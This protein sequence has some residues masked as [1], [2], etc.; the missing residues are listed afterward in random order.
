MRAITR[1]PILNLAAQLQESAGAGDW[2]R[3][4]RLDRQV[5]A[6]LAAVG[7]PP[8]E[9]RPALKLLKAAH[10]EAMNRVRD[11]LRRLQEHIRELNH[12]QEGL[13][14]YAQSGEPL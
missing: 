12:N 11:E 9:L 10:G 4:A 3:V 6:L 7:T 2:A 5:A 13:K 1:E 8:E 14:A